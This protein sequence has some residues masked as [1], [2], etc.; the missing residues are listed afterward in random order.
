MSYKPPF[1]FS[2][3][4]YRAREAGLA[5][6]GCHYAAL[7]DGV[8]TRDHWGNYVKCE[9]VW[10]GPAAIGCDGIGSP[11]C[12]YAD[13]I[14]SIHTIATPDL[15]TVLGIIRRSLLTLAEFPDRASYVAAMLPYARG[16]DPERI[17]DAW[18]LDADCAM[19]A[20]RCLPA[21]LLAWL[22]SLQC[23]R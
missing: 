11:G 3:A 10:I 4:D 8:P 5:V 12:A 14:Q 16:T 1:P 18:A 2:A 13:V 7:P 19:R 17:G 21:D 20:E 9:R 15:G 22:K 23:G 6:L